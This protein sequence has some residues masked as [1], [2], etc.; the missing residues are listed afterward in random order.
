MAIAVGVGVIVGAAVGVGTGAGVAVGS[1]VGVAPAHAIGGEH[2][3]QARPE[4]GVAKAQR[5]SPE[6]GQ[7]RTPL[8]H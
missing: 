4:R 8:R 6:F 1:G 2:C 5:Q 7:R 3:E